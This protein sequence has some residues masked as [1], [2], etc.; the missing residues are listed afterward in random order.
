MAAHR[1]AV[2]VPGGSPAVPEPPEPRARTA[3]AVP[4]ESQSQLLGVLA[5]YGRAEPGSFSVDDLE[6][7]RSLARQAGIGIENVLLHEEA[8]RLS[9]TDG[10]TG[11]WNRRY[12]QMRL[13][14]EFQRAARFGRQLSVLVIDIDHFKAVNDRHGH[15]RGDSTLIEI[16]RRMLSQIRSEVD[17]LARY[18]GEEFALIL[19]ETAGDGART[20]AE[21]IRL[22]VAAT[23]LGDDDEE[24]SHVTVS[25]GVASYPENGVTPQALLH[26]ADQAMYE[27]KGR[28]RN[29]VVGAGEMPAVSL[30]HDPARP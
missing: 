4:I 6:T 7:L 8:Q 11:I 10:L 15:Q 9:I 2:L 28:G 5:I 30:A 29:R 12:F 25:V 24:P 18:G 17:T 3:I 23:P 19:P 26:A 20:V 27:A 21:K 13:A 22:E 1:D 14:Q 16:A